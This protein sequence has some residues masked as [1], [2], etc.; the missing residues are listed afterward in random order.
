MPARKIGAALGR[1]IGGSIQRDCTMSKPDHLA[2]GVPF[3]PARSR[4]VFLQQALAGAASVAGGI[5]WSG[6]ASAIAVSNAAPL[7]AADDL[8]YLD[9]D[10][11]AKL[12]RQKKVSPVQLIQA[13]LTRIEA[14]NPTLAHS[15]PSPR[16]QH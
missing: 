14:L 13:C 5:G 16:N 1:S 12:V 7:T 4:R 6:S 8:A 15:S 11:A 2:S 3:R 9:L 10:E